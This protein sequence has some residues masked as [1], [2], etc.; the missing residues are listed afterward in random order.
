[1][2]GH[3]LQMEQQHVCPTRNS[4]MKVLE[5]SYCPR[6]SIS[7][8][9]KHWPAIQPS[10]GHLSCVRARGKQ[11]TWTERDGEANL[12]RSVKSY[13]VLRI[14]LS[15]GNTEFDHFCPWGITAQTA[16]ADIQLEAAVELQVRGCSEFL[17]S[18]LMFTYSL[19]ISVGNMF[20]Q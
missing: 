3:W 16:V 7:C 2:V 13:K 14:S 19:P 8:P 4:E 17:I 9:W 5:G 18:A 6:G 1:M 15:P 10:W 20:E 11:G 12:S